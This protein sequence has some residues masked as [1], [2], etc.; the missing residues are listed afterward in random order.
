MRALPMIV[1]SMIVCYGSSLSARPHAARMT[2]RTRT[3]TASP[4]PT[5]ATI[6]SNAAVADRDHVVAASDVLSWGVL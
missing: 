3:T 5:S 4:P 2:P 6:R 1:A